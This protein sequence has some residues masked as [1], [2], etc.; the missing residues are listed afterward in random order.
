MVNIEAFWPGFRRLLEQVEYSVSFCWWGARWIKCGKLFA[1]HASTLV[2]FPLESPAQQVGGV[3][4]GCYGEDW[5]LRT[6]LTGA[7][8]ARVWTPW[9]LTVP[10]KLCLLSERAPLLCH[11]PILQLQ[12]GSPALGVLHIFHLVLSDGIWDPL[13]SH[14]LVVLIISF[15]VMKKVHWGHCECFLETRFNF[16]RFVGNEVVHCVFKY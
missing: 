2:C 16:S 15:A 8:V 12:L 1:D 4:S 6:G 10:G 14:S 9:E 11:A 5:I 7:V 3:P 13:N